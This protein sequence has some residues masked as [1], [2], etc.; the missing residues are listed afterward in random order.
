MRRHR[1]NTALAVPLFI[2]LLAA[3]AIVQEGLVSPWASWGLPLLAAAG[4]FVA[5]A[6]VIGLA[7]TLGSGKPSPEARESCGKAASARQEPV[8][9]SGAAEEAEP[10]MALAEALDE[11]EPES[12]MDLVGALQEMGR[13][14]DAL[15]VLARLAEL[16]EGDY[17]EDMAR[18][19]RRMR[20][21]W[22]P[23]PS[24]ST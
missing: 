16:K 12:L 3:P 1:R 8:G 21:Q 6:G 5:L 19:L 2:A 18:A 10:D 7:R 24:A 17:R 14:G 9:D 22:R 4:V 15:E 13:H 11:L 20:R 23:E